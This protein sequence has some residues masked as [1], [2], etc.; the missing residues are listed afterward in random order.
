MKRGI[1]WGIIVLLALW[2]LLSFPKLI[3]P[4]YL[5]TPVAVLREFWA[6]VSSGLLPRHA[7][8]TVYRLVVGFSAG[9]LVGI[10]VGLLMGY[11][12]RVYSALEALI[13]VL[14]AIPVIALFPLFLIFFGLG[15]RSKFIVAAWSSSLVILINTMYGVQHSSTVRRMVARSLKASEWQ[16]FWKVVLP[17]ALPEI[18]VGLR[19]GVSIAL[20]VVLMTEMFLGTQ[21][22]IGQM[23]YNAHLMYDTPTMYVGIIASGVVGYGLNLLLL[24]AQRK[25]IHWKGDFQNE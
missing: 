10:P 24:T 19:T 6:S 21:K 22:G 20:I 1:P 14:R 13:E 15:D 5:P 3:D 12:K 23:I 17:D 16:I 18:L 8:A 7:A 4:L 9:A 2:C 25:V 11:S